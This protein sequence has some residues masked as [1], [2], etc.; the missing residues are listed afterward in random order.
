MKRKKLLIMLIGFLLI[1][2]LGISFAAT[3]KYRDPE[4]L[5]FSMVPAEAVEKEITLYKPVIQ[6]LEKVTGKKIDFYMP[7]NRASVIEA[8]VNRWVDI[9]VFGP[10]SYVMAHELDP[11]IVVFATYAKR[12]GPLTKEGPGYQSVLIT[13]KGSKFTTI[14]SLKGAILALT[15]PASTSGNLVPRVIFC[16]EVLHGK[17][18]EDYFGKVVYSGGHDLSALAVHDGRVDAAFVASHRFDNVIYRGLVEKEDFN[19][20]WFSPVIPGDPFCYLTDLTPELREKIKHTFLTL[21]EVPE[22]KKFLDNV[23]SSKFVEMK[24]SDYDIIRELKEAKEKM[25]L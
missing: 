2:C 24:D 10:Y 1:V 6:Y 25:G 12:P 9:A 16:K 7:T 19:F 20:L 8:M 11:H 15:D 18:L 3:A 5:T 23:A 4:T 14:E 22:C 13:K 21:H 17:P